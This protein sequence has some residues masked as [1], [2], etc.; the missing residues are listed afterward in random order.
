MRVCWSRASL[1]FECYFLV[2]WFF[3]CNVQDTWLNCLRRMSALQTSSW[4]HV[5][6]WDPRLAQARVCVKWLSAVWVITRY[7]VFSQTVQICCFLMVYS[8]EWSINFKFSSCLYIFFYKYHMFQTNN[9]Y[10][11]LFLRNFNFAYCFGNSWYT[12]N[13][14]LVSRVWRRR[15]TQGIGDEIVSAIRQSTILLY[16]KSNGKHLVKSSFGHG[17][18]SKPKM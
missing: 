17:C 6:S 10:A 4:R 13:L 16:M 1:I 3:F 18:Q 11:F 9:C 2:L 7:R 8:L 5:T 14:K 12:V 15:E